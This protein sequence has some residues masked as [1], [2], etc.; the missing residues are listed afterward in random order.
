VADDF[1]K[2]L[3]WTLNQARMWC[4]AVPRG[5]RATVLALADRVDAD[6]DAFL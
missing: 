2:T 4:V 6:G 5:N 1:A 3:P